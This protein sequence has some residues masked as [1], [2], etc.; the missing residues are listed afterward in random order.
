M[1]GRQ[2]GLSQPA[3]VQSTYW[4]G[5]WA[6]RHLSGH[7]SSLF[8]TRLESKSLGPGSSLSQPTSFSVPHRST[9]W[10]SCLPL[11]SLPLACVRYLP[12]LPA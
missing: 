9:L 8:S 12:F 2:A 1:G 6:L 7:F 4:P 3:G 11:P 10:G 5:G